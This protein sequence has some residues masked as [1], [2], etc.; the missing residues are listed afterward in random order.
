[1]IAL[2][3]TQVGNSLGVVLPKDALNDLQVG[4]G[5]TLYLTRAPDGSMRLSAYSEVVAEQID[6]ARSV[7]RQYRET[8]RALSK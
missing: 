4:K 3:V 8:L 2:K 6:A 7:M 5:D 1:M